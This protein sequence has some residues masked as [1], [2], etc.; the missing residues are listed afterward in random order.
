M[1]SLG[2]IVLARRSD[3]NNG[4]VDLG[5]RG[6]TNNFMTLDLNTVN[7]IGTG[8]TFPRRCLHSFLE[9]FRGQQ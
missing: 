8:T 2:R 9:C 5:R 1:V 3:H 4:K 7:D 6:V